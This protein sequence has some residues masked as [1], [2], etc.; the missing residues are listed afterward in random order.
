MPRLAAE[1]V[2][3]V[4]APRAQ[5][6]LL[7]EDDLDLATA[8]CVALQNVAEDVEIAGTLR[9]ARERLTRRRWDLVVLDAQLP[10]G[11]GFDL[12]GE[13]S[14]CDSAA[15]VLL[16]TA[17]ASEADRVAGLELGADDYITKPFSVRELLLRAGN[18]LK[19]QKD[20][21]GSASPAE[22]IVCGDVI[23][24]TGARR[25][26]CRG[27]ELALAPREFDL[28]AYLARHPDRV[29]TRDQLLSAVWGEQFEGFDHTVNAHISRLR[30]KIEPD[31]RRPQRLVT[32]WG[33]GYR[34]VAAC[35]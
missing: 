32:V 19:R 9:R 25:A 28:L 33:S 31:P 27:V 22:R 17:R 12:C 2:P 13:L 20:G 18:L 23:I 6:I 8:L 15:A 30:A 29:F 34:F 14:R 21:K 11:D 5:S 7:V 35:P 3:A 16:L 1:Y 4:F 24:E 10:D 26:R